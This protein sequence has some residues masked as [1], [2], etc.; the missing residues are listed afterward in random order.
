MVKGEAL[1]AL[2]G[3]FFVDIEDTTFFIII[4]KYLQQQAQN[5]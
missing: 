3:N 2:V 5:Y 4:S 1:L